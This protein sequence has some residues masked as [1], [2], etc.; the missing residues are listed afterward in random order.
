[1]RKQHRHTHTNMCK[2]DDQWEASYNTEP[3]LHS[4]TTQRDGWGVR[5][6]KEGGGYMYNYD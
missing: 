3:A 4:V 1:M 2:T 5:E 6:A